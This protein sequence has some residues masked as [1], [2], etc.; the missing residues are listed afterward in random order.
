MSRVHSFAKYRTSVQF[1]RHYY[2]Y[3]P[4]ISISNR[5][6]LKLRYNHAYCR[7]S[8][9][10][11]VANQAQGRHKHSRRPRF[12]FGA[13][14]SKDW[15]STNLSSRR[16]VL[17]CRAAISGRC[18]GAMATMRT[19]LLSVMTMNDDDYKMTSRKS[20]ISVKLTISSLP[21]LRLP[22]L[23]VHALVTTHLF[24]DITAASGRYF[25]D[26]CVK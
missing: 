12:G 25:I 13:R 8:K 14:R 5:A 6:S 1:L 22:K 20:W 3:F 19:D 24:A 10:F 7:S 9:K 16:R 18:W 26:L 2:C 15:C 4:P 23:L 21:L 17:K 11:T